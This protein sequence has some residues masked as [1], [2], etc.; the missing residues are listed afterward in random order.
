MPRSRTTGRTRTPCR[1]PSGSAT[2]AVAGDAGKSP[3]GV[4]ASP[5]RL[6]AGS[7][8]G[9]TRAA[10][11]GCGLLADPFP[12]LGSVEAAGSQDDGRTRT[13]VA[14]EVGL[15]RTALERAQT[16]IKTTLALEAPPPRLHRSGQRT[17]LTLV[18]NLSDVRQPLWRAGWNSILSP[19]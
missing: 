4:R 5:G 19:V 14:R 6:D 9:A 10:A 7:A 15:H 3:Q 16:A 11:E 13:K 17:N 8:N 1:F 2:G 12:G 18:E